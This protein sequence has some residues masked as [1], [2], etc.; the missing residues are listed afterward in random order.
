MGEVT[1]RPEAQIRPF[2]FHRFLA[3]FFALASLGGAGVLSIFFTASSKVVGG[4]TIGLP[5]LPAGLGRYLE[6]FILTPPVTAL[7]LGLTVFV[8]EGLNV[9]LPA[10]R[11]PLRSV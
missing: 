7:A 3:D 5:R 10:A 8:S 2:G 6:P 1:A 9:G 4:R 11:R